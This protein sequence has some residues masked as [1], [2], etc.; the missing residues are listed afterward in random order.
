M[1]E[2]PDPAT[3]T[4]ASTSGRRLGAPP[5]R[6]RLRAALAGC[7]ALSLQFGPVTSPR[8]EV[9]GYVDADGRSH[10]ASERLDDRY[11][12]FFRGDVV[13]PEDR[14]IGNG[15]ASDSASPAPSATR[16]LSPPSPYDDLIRRHAAQQALDPWLVKAVV[17]VESAFQPNAVSPKGARGLMQVMPETAARYGITA[18]RRGSAE[19]QLLDPATNIGVGTR[20]LRDLLMR[21]ANDVP[22]A[23][24]AYNA[25]EMAVARYRNQ[26]PPYP[27]TT[28][29]VRQVQALAEAWR[30][31]PPVA[32]PVVPA[33]A[34]I[35]GT[36]LSLPS[37]AAAPV[38]DP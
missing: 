32:P 8:A 16:I 33:R 9:W 29:Y 25:G 34:R 3:T 24:A 21:F 28:A 17:A 31:A 22:L 14:H 5:G 30:P 2:R 23:L 18:D 7:L 20:Y 19:Q 26:I 15:A 27:E 12:L 35:R 4:D 10:L 1:L 38:A 36:W 13:A 11:R 6:V 37:H